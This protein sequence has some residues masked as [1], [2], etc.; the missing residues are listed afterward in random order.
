ML[1][2]ILQIIVGLFLILIGVLLYIID[3][4]AKI[5]VLGVAQ[6]VEQPLDKG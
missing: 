3:S 5:V 4:V 1:M 6:L 2:R